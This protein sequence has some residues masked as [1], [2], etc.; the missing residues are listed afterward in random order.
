VPRWHRRSGDEA[1]IITRA[2]NAQTIETVTALRA[3][4]SAPIFGR[5]DTWGLIRRLA[6]CIDPS[7]PHLGCASQEVHVLQVLDGMERDG[8]RDPDLILAALVHDIGKVLLTTDEHPANIVCMNR[9]IGQHAPG[10]GLDHCLLQWGHDEIGYDRLRPFVSE[11]VAWLVRYH[12]IDLEHCAPLM[13]E[14]DRTYTERYLRPFRHYD[15]GT[16][17]KHFMP[18]KR[19][20]D[21]RHIAA[22]AL[23]RQLVF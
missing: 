12:S 17:S 19:M 18:R 14:R 21:Y 20:N 23:P 10:I 9:P 15:L 22:A 5:V 13:N 4:Y 16:K 3:K 11:P 2:H 6:E 1:D 8:V 7:D